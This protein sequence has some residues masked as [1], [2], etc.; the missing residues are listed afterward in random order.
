MTTSERILIIFCVVVF[1]VLDQNRA[2]AQNTEQTST[3][4]SPLAQTAQE[5]NSSLGDNNTPRQHYVGIGI[6]YA[7]GRATFGRPEAMISALYGHT[8]THEYGL[9]IGLHYLA[10]RMF[11]YGL[12]YN[13]ISTLGVR[14]S[15]TADATFMLYGQEGFLKN[16]SFGIGP[17]IRTITSITTGLV[18]LLNVPDNTHWFATYETALDLGGNV[19]LDYMLPI[20]EQVECAFRIQYHQFLF[21]SIGYHIV[22]S[23]GSGSASIGAF[24]RVRF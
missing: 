3:A 11:N 23:S 12:T 8:F 13:G 5:V 20:D 1:S 4:G 24:L 22:T 19:K 7:A 18:T 2:M 17:S 16:F 10:G 15:W 9:E 6:S 21:P 14:T